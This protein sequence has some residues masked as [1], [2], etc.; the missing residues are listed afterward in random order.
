MLERRHFLGA[1]LGSVLVPTLAVA[2][3]QGP[4]AGGSG[5]LGLG[6]APL[7]GASA[8]ERMNELGRK[9]PLWRH[10]CYAYTHRA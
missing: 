9:T 8:A 5:Q 7:L 6:N 1:G 3:A 2:Q 10:T 4:K